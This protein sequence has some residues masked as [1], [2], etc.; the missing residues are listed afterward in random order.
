MPPT[1]N[2]DLPGDDKAKKGGG[3]GAWVKKNK[4]AAAGAGIIGLAGVIYIIR[5]N[6]T[7]SST[8][9]TNTTT[10][11]TSQTGLT[12]GY[13]TDPS[14]YGYGGGGD[15]GNQMADLQ[16]LL[17]LYTAGVNAGR[18]ST[19]GGTGTKKPTGGGGKKPTGGGKKTTKGGTWTNGGQTI[20]TGHYKPPKAGSTWKPSGKT[21]IT[22]G[23]PKKFVLGGGRIINTPHP[24]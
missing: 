19:S 6:S 4:A 11:D 7:S 20:F 8:T 13:A 21:I 22:P 5:R 17:S 9:P 16:D 23:Q 2:S 15:Y 3:L 14:L 1:T 12:N 18:A 24:K 10:G